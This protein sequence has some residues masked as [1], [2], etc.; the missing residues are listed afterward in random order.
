[1][2]QFASIASVSY[3]LLKSDRD[4]CFPCYRDIRY[5][6]MYFQLPFVFIAFS[7]S[8][9]VIVGPVLQYYVFLSILQSLNNSSIILSSQ[10]VTM[11]YHSQSARLFISVDLAL[12]IFIFFPLN[13]WVCEIKSRSK[14]LYYSFSPVSVP[15]VDRSP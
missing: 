4:D 5:F 8:S 6:C 13:F 12:T 10:I 15:Y 3:I 1:M 11:T 14:L 7:S 2:F 9:A